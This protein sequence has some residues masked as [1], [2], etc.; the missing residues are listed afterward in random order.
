MKI[1]HEEK[2]KIFES[3]LAEL[4]KH[5]QVNIHE[6]PK[7]EFGISM[8]ARVVAVIETLKGTQFESDRLMI[9]ENGLKMIKNDAMSPEII[10]WIEEAMDAYLRSSLD[11]ALAN[12]KI[13]L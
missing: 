3:H 9:W 11:A 5:V 10:T 12:M 6:D 2:K 8:G 1:E 7:S 13:K 4:I